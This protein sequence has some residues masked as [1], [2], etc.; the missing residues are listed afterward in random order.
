MFVGLMAFS[1]AEDGFKD[2]ELQHLWLVLLLRVVGWACLFYVPVLWIAC[3]SIRYFCLFGVGPCRW[4][5][6]DCRLPWTHRIAPFARR[7][8]AGWPALDLGIGGPFVHRPC[9]PVK[10]QLGDLPLQVGR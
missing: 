9:L 1:I 10:H 6:V 8:R 2:V 7:F 5:S 3:G 4:L